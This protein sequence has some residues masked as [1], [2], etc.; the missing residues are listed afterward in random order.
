MGDPLS[1]PRAGRLLSADLGE[2]SALGGAFRTVAHQAQSAAAGLRGAQNDATWTGQAAD[3]FRTQVGKLPGDLD[4]VQQSYGEVGTALDTYGIELGP[5]QSSFRSLSN[6]LSTARSNLS[7]AQTQLQTAQSDLTTATSAPHAKP[8]STAVVDAHSAVSSA[9]GAVGRLQG[10]VSAL[11]SRGY[12]LLDE[13]DTIRGRA[14]WTVASAA[15]VAPSESWLSSAL[16]AVGNFVEGAVKGIAKSVWDLVSGKAV[17]DF[18]EHPSWATFGELVKDVAVTASLVAMVV[19]PFAAPELASADAAVAGAEGADAAAA[20]ADA[21]AGGAEGASSGGA[22]AFANGARA[23]SNGAVKTTT[24]AGFVSSYADAKQGKW[25]AAGLDLAFIAA[26]NLGH[27]PTGLGDVTTFGDRGANLLG[28]GEKQAAAADSN[29]T[30]LKDFQGWTQ[31]GLNPV[32][33]KQISFA[34][35]E[36]PTAARSFDLS[37]LAGQD[38]AIANAKTLADKA[39]ATALHVGRPVA[40]GIDNLVTDPAKEHLTNTIA[41]EPSCG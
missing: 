22:S 31:E 25:A 10:D 11:E 28:V 32:A 7:G 36:F 4:K 35:G 24:A 9:S 3:A 15:G 2:I 40:I 17:I 38:A 27:M 33:A 5:I 14:F 16:S 39:A 20:G 26:P 18:I 12:S 19:A 6:Q 34:N 37:N 1:D 8:T 29:L 13:F 41:P 21:A 30:G 23:V